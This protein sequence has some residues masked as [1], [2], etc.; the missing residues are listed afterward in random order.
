MFAYIKKFFSGIA[1]G[2]T[3]MKEYKAKKFIEKINK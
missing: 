1:D 2:I 3:L